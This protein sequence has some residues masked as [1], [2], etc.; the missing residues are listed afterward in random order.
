MSRR[1]YAACLVVLALVAG[2][3][4]DPKPGVEPD[5]TPTAVT[6]SAS[7]S[8]TV[9]PSEEPETAEE[10][11]RRWVAE[12]EDMQANG[13]SA[14]FRTT[15][16]GC[17]ECLA[18]SDRFESI[19][20]SGGFIRGGDITVTD[21]RRAGRIGNAETWILEFDATTTRYRE[22]ARAPA[23]SLEGGHSGFRFVLEP[24]G[25]AFRIR[26][27]YQESL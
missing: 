27:L 8:P 14:P 20:T 4:G 3:S 16:Q 1:W 10:F 9:E 6:P 22:E 17:S 2:C 12:Y 15:S 23:Q 19:Y 13:D 21:V 11:L 5:P 26:E 25:G 7:A 24:Q 18:I